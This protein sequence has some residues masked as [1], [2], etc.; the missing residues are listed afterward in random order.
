MRKI[1][2]LFTMMAAT[3]F[4]GTGL[5]GTAP[6]GTVGGG[7]GGAYV[8]PSTGTPD[9]Q[10]VDLFEAETMGLHI[11]YDNQTP[12]AVQINAAIE[13]VSRISPK[14]GADVRK[15]IDL[16]Q[17][18]LAGGPGVYVPE[19]NDVD[20]RYRKKGCELKGMM[21]FD[22]NWGKLVRDTNLFDAQKTITDFTA[23]YLHEAV[24]KV[25]RDQHMPA[26]TNSVLT[27][28][29]VG[30]VIPDRDVGECLGLTPRKA[31]TEA[32]AWDC[33]VVN[34][35]STKI[36]FT[37]FAHDN[38]ASWSVQL[39]K[40]NDIPLLYQTRS[41]YYRSS[42]ES[43]MGERSRLGKFQ[44]SPD[45]GAGSIRGLEGLG[46]PFFAILP[47]IFIVRPRPVVVELEEGKTKFNCQS[48]QR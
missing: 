33:S 20:E 2:G 15:A 26:S 10:L 3:A 37:L 45:F 17:A 14:L 41:I 25:M 1:L 46:N 48:S 24:Y 27:R 5:A 4:A 43:E 8:C 19:P 38:F 13:K 36:S 6:S 11:N 18:N 44:P 35:N 9:V 28:R 34:K 40:F 23:S 47:R 31:V 39:N 22:D 30:C 21:F 42:F 12:L 29:I 16:V 32:D 7:G